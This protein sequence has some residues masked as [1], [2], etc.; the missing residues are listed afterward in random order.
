MKK[1]LTIIALCLIGV[2]ATA[3]I[4]LACIKYNYN[5][6]AL[7][8]VTAVQIYNGSNNELFEKEI[9]VDEYNQ[10][11]DLYKKGAKQNLLN[12]LFQGNLG[13]EIV[14]NRVSTTTVTG[15]L[16][17]TGTIAIKFYVQPQESLVI[18]G[19]EYKYNDQSISYDYITILLSN[20][21]N[22]QETTL[23]FTSS[24]SS[25]YYSYSVTCYANFYQLYQY[26]AGFDNWSSY[27]A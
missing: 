9:K 2:L 20:V 8:N 15:K 18:D 6:I 17:S 5:V 27:T 24:N 16:G 7:D 21:N 12:A 3:T 1:I 10:V 14:V 13:H 19:K 23:Y 25:S 11:L 22:V 4:V 26:I